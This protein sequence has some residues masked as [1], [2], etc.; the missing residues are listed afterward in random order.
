MISLAAYKIVLTRKEVFLNPLK[1]N[2]N[3]LFLI[4][5]EINKFFY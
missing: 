2:T 5:K 4:K 1:K 3:L